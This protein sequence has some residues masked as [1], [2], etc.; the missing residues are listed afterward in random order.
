MATLCDAQIA[1]TDGIIN[2]NYF[3][4]MFCFF[5]IWKYNMLAVDG[6]ENTY[7]LVSTTVSGFSLTK[8]FLSGKIYFFQMSLRNLSC[9]RFKFIEFVG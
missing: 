3:L 1:Q 2:Y 7:V 5:V 8:W 4:V 6:S 9:L